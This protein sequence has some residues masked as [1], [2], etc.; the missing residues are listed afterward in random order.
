M[1]ATFS[2]D[3]DTE[4]PDAIADALRGVA[5]QLDTRGEPQARTVRVTV[6]SPQGVA[7]V[8]TSVVVGTTYTLPVDVAEVG[9]HTVQVT[10]P[11]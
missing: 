9:Q 8:A 3:L 2:I 10:V 6:L 4:D 5:D 7:L 11:A 1:I